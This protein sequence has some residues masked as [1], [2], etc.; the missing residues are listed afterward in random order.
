MAS[1]FEFGIHTNFQLNS[2]LSL[3]LGYQGLYL[4][5]L[6]TAPRQFQFGLD[7]ASRHGLDRTGSLFFF[8]PAAGIE[9]K[10]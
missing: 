6:S 3:Q 5:D 9:W 10:W 2:N 4:N 8:G 1:L 7:P